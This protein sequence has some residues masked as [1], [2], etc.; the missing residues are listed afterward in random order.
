M[1]CQFP[2]FF[3]SY[4]LWSFYLSS[5]FILWFL[6]LVVWFQQ[7]LSIFYCFPVVFHLCNCFNFISHWFLELC[8]CSFQLPFIL[9]LFWSLW[10]LLWTFV[11]GTMLWNH[12]RLKTLISCDV[13]NILIL[14]SFCMCCFFLYLHLL[15]SYGG[16]FL[17]S[18]SVLVKWD[19]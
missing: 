5:A 1:H 4:C 19:Q 12:L 10:F 9:L 16:P 14:P 2:S 18:S 11:L 13:Y 17:I 7:H 3:H 8:L 6:K 15:I